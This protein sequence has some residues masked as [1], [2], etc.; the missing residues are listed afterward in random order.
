M[1]L[2]LAQ[3]LFLWLTQSYFVYLGL[4]IGTTPLENMILSVWANRLYPYINTTTPGPM[5]K[6]AKQEILRS[7]KAMMLH[8]V[9][10]VVVFG[11]DNLLISY[12]VGAVAVGLYSNYLMVTNGLKTVYQQIFRALAASVGNLGA[13]AAPEQ[14]RSVFQRMTLA[15]NWLYGF[16]AVCL[17]SLFNQFIALWVGK[18]FLLSQEIVCLIALNFYV[19]GMR[20]VVLTFR[21]AQGNSI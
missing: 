5:P 12:F 8:K 2:Y 11:T 19:T 18:D 9:G 20:Q 10:G 21:E 7:A 4:R 15:G 14:A 1:L 16:S 3:A 17:V 6:E 13:M